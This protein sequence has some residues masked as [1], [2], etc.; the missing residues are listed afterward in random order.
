MQLYNL[1]SCSGFGSDFMG[2]CSMGWLGLVMLFFIVAVLRKW[3]GEEVGMDF[4]FLWALVI[5]FAAD[6]VVISLTGSVKWSLAAGIV[7]AIIGGYG[8]GFFGV[9][10]DEE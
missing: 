4:S 6:I 1:M 7:G 9:G 10:G 5:G 2:G 8:L 3:G